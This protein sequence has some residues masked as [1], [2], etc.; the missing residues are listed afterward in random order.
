M[1]ANQEA[2]TLKQNGEEIKIKGNLSDLTSFASSN[3]AQGEHNW[4][5]I[6]ID[7]KLE[8][9]VGATWNGATLTQEDADEATGLGLPAGHIVYWHKADE[10]GVETSITI[11]TEEDEITY[12]VINDLTR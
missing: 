5:G 1:V 12:T 4:V 6:D 10:A 7:T 9:I 8:T 11:G 2:I 3:P